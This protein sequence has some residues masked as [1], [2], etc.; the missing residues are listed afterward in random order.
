A[1]EAVLLYELKKLDLKVE[2]QVPLPLV[3]ESI[4]MEVGYRIDIL[5]EKRSLLR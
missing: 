2:A 1:Y 3:Y 4:S 5:V